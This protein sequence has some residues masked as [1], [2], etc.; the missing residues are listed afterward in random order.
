M[1]VTDSPLA[2]RGSGVGRSAR[3]RSSPDAPR[4]ALGLAT[5]LA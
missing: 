1:G 2:V 5:R 4:D 3:R